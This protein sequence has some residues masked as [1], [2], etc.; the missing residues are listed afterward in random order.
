MAVR[1]END[2]VECPQGCIDCG[3]KRTKHYYCDRCK[4]EVEKIY[5]FEGEELCIDC[6]EPLL[7][8][9]E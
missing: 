9:V 2:C 1:I 3:L 4:D 6:I 5:H 7:Q 8:E